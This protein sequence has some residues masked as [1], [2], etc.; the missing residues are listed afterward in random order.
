MKPVEI[1]FLF[2][3]DGRGLGEMSSDLSG[4][5]ARVN[6][7]KSTI[8]DLRRQMTALLN[9]KAAP[10]M[11]QSANIK[12]VEALKSKITELRK[13]V[14]FLEKE[15]PELG[16]T[17]SATQMTPPGM[18]GVNATYSNL[19][20]SIQQ[21]AREM[22]TLAM[23]PQMFFMAIS[24]NLPVFTD[25]LARARQEYDSLVKSGAKGTPVWRQ[26]V[27]SLFS[28]QTALTAGIM[29]LT[30]YG[31]KMVE[32]IG[33]VIK[34]KDAAVSAT[35][36]VKKMNEAMDTEDVAG[37]I[38][39]FEKLSRAYK[40]LGDN[41]AEKKKF[42][43]KYRDEIDKT[44]ISVKNIKDADN[45]FINN[46][47]AF[48]EAIKQRALALAGMKLASE[49]YEKALKTE[50][51]DRAR[52]AASEAR[53]EMLRNK[54]EDYW[55]S[56]GVQTSS[57]G[58]TSSVTR[59][60]DELI[61]DEE[62]TIAIIKK[63]AQEY[64]NAGDAYI[65]AA[66]KMSAEAEQTLENA[67]LKKLKKNSDKNSDED[68]TTIED[69]KKKLAEMEEAAQEEVAEM[70][71]KA[72]KKGYE[73]ERE[74]AK[75]EFEQEKKRIANEL[76]KRLALYA[77]L[78]KAG[79][80]VPIGAEERT[81][82]TAAALIVK[83][84]TVYDT[85]LSEI[86]A[87]EQKDA[88]EREKK[89]EEQLQKLLDK[90]RG[91]ESQ[92]IALRK[93]GNE[94]IAALEAARMAEN[95]EEIDRAIAD[96][97]LKIEQG[98]QD[99]NDAEARS[100]AKDNG[101]LKRLFGDW[102]SM[103]FGSLKELISQA[104]Q[105][106]DYLSGTGD[107]KGITFI[108]TDQLKAIEQSPEELDKIKKAIDGLLNKGS[109][110][111]S[112]WSNLF[113]TFEKGLAKLKDAKGIEEISGA[114]GTIG[115][116]ASEAAGELA[117]MFDAMGN[118][119]AADAISG[120]QKGLSAVSNIAEGFAKGGII[121]AAGAAVGEI[122]KI[123]TSAI[124]AEHRHTEALKEIEKA[125]LSFQRQY[126]LLLLEQNLLL[127]EASNIF[128]EQQI[129]KATNALAVFREAQ[130]E[131]EQALKRFD[132]NRRRPDNIGGNT[133]NRRKRYDASL[134][135]E[136][137]NGLGRAT[138]VT[139]H[140][141]T[142]LFGWGKGRDVYSSILEVY[143]ELIDAN[144]KLDTA[145]L[146]TILDTR[147]M[148]DET[149]EYLQNLLNL[150]DVMKDAKE[151]LRDYLGE[152]YGGLGDGLLDSVLAGIDGSKDALEGFA[153]SIGDTFEKLGKQLAYSLYFA[154][155]FDKLQKELEELYGSGRNEKD[156]TEDAMD[157][158]DKFYDNIGDN[159]DDA[160]SFFQK[161]KE[162]AAEKGFD[163]WDDEASSQSGKTGAF[164]TMTQDQGTK[165]EGL[166]TAGQIHWSNM[167]STLDEMGDDIYSGL[168]CLRNIE[169]N[170]ARGLLELRA[171]KAI[172]SGMIR[173]GVKVR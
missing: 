109:G 138:I 32:W 76:K 103:S 13:E 62:K 100:S 52:I 61:A 157:L 166:F 89:A 29:L 154:D 169:S 96:A 70:T 35:S 54:P 72:M 49:Q 90:Y 36:A 42:I 165:L 17:I 97:K 107:S 83:A 145:M 120:V 136:Y 64:R 116:A 58:T 87:E 125:R 15:Y 141:K 74:E 12:K 147:K 27:S 84:G 43:E 55:E 150:N 143:P 8:A 95:Y 47:D 69:K 4:V 140:E 81:K 164:N 50:D 6:A 123:A 68:E 26:V 128:G 80:D 152:T 24:N 28:W 60:R 93:Q 1:E 67:G 133:S 160:L 162:K 130:Q 119:D 156:I 106:K 79:A 99:I 23:G 44:G 31:G 112:K 159:A 30:M 144:G 40:A 85:R 101:F 137:I 148:S 16:K 20:N 153:D 53:I 34:G 126:N 171:I 19:H 149:R 25:A 71:V 63:R 45:L 39:D 134:Y 170:T 163:I 38:A 91:Y 56:S 18:G 132:N 142:G 173:D 11:D 3:Q 77:E 73:R 88:A 82:A 117:D 46:T 105:L 14:A 9:Q 129:L 122:A 22:P 57:F 51:N 118:T 168:D 110:G 78:R 98:I 48:I 66:N 75:L 139:G 92:R 86:D 124:E 111:S 2:K 172:I 7:T 104:R 115:G 37:Q 127:E 21:I 102:S 65:D 151:A 113:K 158:L 155:E 108:A 114:I 10:D 131:F 5:Q 161:W 33:K 94:D 167:D 59:S 41:A 121:G 135:D 146:Q